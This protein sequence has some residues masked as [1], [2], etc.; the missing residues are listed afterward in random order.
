MNEFLLLIQKIPAAAWAAFVTAIITSSITLFGVR[1]TNQ[2][3]NERLKIQLDHERESRKQELISE[4]LEELYVESKKYMNSIV[5]H[6]LPYIKVMQGE[7]TYDDVLD[8][9]LNTKIEHNYERVLLIMDMYFPELRDSFSKV[10]A[11]LAKTNEIKNKY[12][13]Q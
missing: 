8:M 10:E 9:T 12:K 2:S 7:I 5:G 11:E 6:F 4:R 3:N 13:L 1:Y